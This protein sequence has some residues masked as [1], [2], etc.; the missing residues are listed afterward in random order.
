MLSYGYIFF[1]WCYATR[2]C[3]SSSK[4]ERTDFRTKWFI[5][6]LIFRRSILG[7]L[8]VECC[9]SSKAAAVEWNDSLCGTDFRTSNF[10]DIMLF[11]PEQHSKGWPPQIQY[12]KKRETFTDNNQS[13]W[14]ITALFQL[15]SIQVKKLSHNFIFWG[16]TLFNS[17]TTN[18]LNRK[19][20]IV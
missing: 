10:F 16:K 12:N 6:V 19:V 9:W 11:L 20:A 5:L 7:D 4:A 13:F 3:C 2:S 1:Y 15:R 17:S 8:P 18:G 14:S